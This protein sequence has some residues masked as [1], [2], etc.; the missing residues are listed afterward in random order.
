MSQSE[1][2][3]S[4]GSAKEVKL[5]SPKSPKKKSSIED[6][7]DELKVKKIFDIIK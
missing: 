3:F 5:D 1:R 2:P 4:V 6:I 7:D